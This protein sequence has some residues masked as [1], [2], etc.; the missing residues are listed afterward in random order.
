MLV[1]IGRL[2]IDLHKGIMLPKKYI[3]SSGCTSEM[4]GEEG[5]RS[6]PVLKS[7]RME[8]LRSLSNEYHQQFV[9]V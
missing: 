3:L 1:W 5:S 7:V 8:M 4:G 9:I 2:V 6:C